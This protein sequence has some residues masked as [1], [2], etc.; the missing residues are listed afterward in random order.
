MAVIA[1]LSINF[2]SFLNHEPPTSSQQSKD[3]LCIERGV[4]I[5]GVDG[6]RQPERHTAPGT[7]PRDSNI[8]VSSG[9]YTGLGFIG[10]RARIWGVRVLGFGG[11]GFGGLGFGVWGF[12]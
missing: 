1:A 4:G 8:P 7:L 3:R 12:I 9:L 5:D 6:R 11:Q 2:K 10:F